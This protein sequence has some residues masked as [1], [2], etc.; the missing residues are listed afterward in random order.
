MLKTSWANGCPCP[1]SHACWTFPSPKSIA[2]SK[3]A[4]WPLCGWVSVKSVQSRPNSFRTAK[5]WTALKA[6]L[7]YWQTRATPTRTSS[8]GF[9]RLMN[10]CGDGLSTHCGKAAKLK[11]GAGRKPWPGNCP[12]WNGESGSP[13]DR[14]FGKPSQRGFWQVV[15]GKRLKGVECRFAKFSD[16]D[17]GGLQGT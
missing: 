11:S 7:L 10:P 9:L 6:P 4:H 15:Q 12:S 2:C 5:W 3:T 16:Q 14:S 17:F 1:T 8:F 13:A